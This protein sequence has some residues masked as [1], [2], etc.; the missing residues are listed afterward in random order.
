MTAAI[1]ENSASSSAHSSASQ[2]NAAAT[3]AKWQAEW[4]SNQVFKA[5]PDQG[6]KPF[7][8]VIPPPN[9]TG[10]LHMGHA[11]EHSLI[12]TLVRYHRM[13]GENT[14]WLPGTD[15]ASIAVQTILEK[16]L[17]AENKSRDE[18]GREAFLERAWAWKAESGST[19][20]GQL[21][22]LGVS[23]DWSRERFTMDAGLSTA[24]LA[25]FNK[26]YEEGLIY[27]SK[28]L[29]NW[30]PASQSAVSDLE[31]ENKEVNGSLWH[32]RYPLSDDSGCIEVATTRPE[33][34]LGDTAVAVNPDDDRYRHLVGRTVRLPIT[35]RQ[36]PIIA[37]SYVDSSFGTGS[38]KITPAH[39][40][41]DFEMGKR[42]NLPMINILN[43]DGSL[44][45]NAGEFQGQD[46]FVARKNVVKRLEAEGFLVKVEE[47]KH[48]VPYSDRGKVP[49][50]PLLST[51]W[52]VK[53][54]PLA[55]RALEFLDAQE[56]QFVPERWTKVYRDWLESLRDW[57]ISRQL[58]WG[59][60]I[61]AWYAIS[62]TNGEITETTPFMV[63][64]SE[65]QAREKAVEQFGEQVQ[66][67]QDPDVLDTWFS[68]GLWPFSTMGWPE[69]TQDLATYYPTT[70]LVTGFDII[71]FWVARMTMLAG[72]F[73]GQMP[74]QTV[75]IHGLVRDEN[76]KKMSKSANNGI[77]PL[78]LIDKYGT[79]ALRFTLVKEVAGAGQDV[80]LEYDRKTDES[81]SVE[82]SRNFTNKI[83]NA[84]RFVML[85]L[86]GQ[87]PTQLGLPDRTALELA[88][89]WIL[90][91]YNQT[92][93]QTRADLDGYGMGE[94]AKRLYEFFWGDL[95]DWYIEL[96][97]SRFQTDSAS[98]R[99]A[100]QVL[101]QLLDGT[102]KLLHPFMPHITEEV[103]QNLT[104]AEGEY[105]ALQGYP[106]S[107][108]DA[109]DPALEQQFDQIIDTIRTIRNL[110]AEAFI[111][112]SAQIETILQTDSLQERQMLLAGQ[113]Y[114]QEMARVGQLTIIQ[115]DAQPDT[116]PEPNE[117]EPD[118]NETVSDTVAE[119]IQ[120]VEEAIS[121]T[122][123][124]VESGVEQTLSRWN[125]A[126]YKKPALVLI[127][128][129]ALWI[130]A[131]LFGAVIGTFHSLPLL[132]PL[133]KLI[134]IGYTGWFIY[135]FLISREK[136]RE[137]AV[138]IRQFRKQMADP[139]TEIDLTAM[140]VSEAIS[141]TSAPA[142]Q[143]FAGVV[144]TVQ[145]LIPLT[146]VVDTE[147][148]SAK[149]QKDLAKAEAE[150]QSLS[151]RLGNA[152]FVDKAPIEVVQNARTAL[153]EAEK[154]AEILKDRLKQLD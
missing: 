78:I 14:L 33:T 116:Q 30:C 124:Q 108:P 21:R 148:L 131:R 48:S 79:D 93:Q 42:H 91:R 151:Q 39:D 40:P 24:V 112:P 63:A 66:I 41:N 29:V 4:E 58:W 1:P 152:N 150:I 132:A 138:Q 96:V 44:N 80:S 126:T 142:D 16:Q 118:L 145:V 103:W 45:E 107:D 89:R 67:Q 90:S 114:I 47:H 133:F 143:M 100:R 141:I 74:F 8:M 110:R 101:A 11:L 127:F 23:V 52:F 97:K 136:R 121:A 3:E 111:K 56:P 102:L 139:V 6:G 60:Q 17:K 87:T 68:A 140:P 99:T 25:A 122:A 134:G 19:I 71:F 59:H 18:I 104:Q 144:G 46:R 65:A 49:V 13:L 5:N 117:P 135:K 146:G 82:A 123:G 69:Q 43:K 10:S 31:V 38:V 94:A 27:R 9:V 53:I 72:H 81:A 54:R 154:Q 12:D 120:Q 7:C 88:D 92:V 28:Y 83:W 75:Y 125:L 32:F 95:C 15:H 149:L 34:M 137:L 37:D 130:L 2:Y 129:L 128:F 61:P 57:C 153:A 22:R 70:T 36:I 84:S 62:E 115:P 98:G 26:L 50:E 73:T 119:T 64:S 109:I 77:D 105:L 113:T 85:N 35:N 55:D 20:V 106:Q 147:V 76:G 86:D 51:Q